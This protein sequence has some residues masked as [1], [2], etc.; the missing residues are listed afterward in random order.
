MLENRSDIVEEKITGPNGT[1]TYYS[2]KI[3]IRDNN[4][5]AIGMLGFSLDITEIKQKEEASRKVIDLLFD[6]IPFVFWKNIDG[7]YQGAN[8]NEAITMGF[9]SPNEMIGKTTFEVTSDKE[10]AKLVNDNDNKVMRENRS[11]IVEETIVGPNGPHT[12]YSQKTP[13]RDEMGKVT[14]MLG[15][16]MDITEHK[17]TVEKLRIEKEAA[18]LSSEIKTQFIQNM[19][20]DLRTPAS[21][22]AQIL[23]FMAED[24]TNPEKKTT[25]QQLA[26]ASQRLLDLLNGI[27]EFDKMST[28]QT[29]IASEKFD[30]YDI[31]NSIIQLETPTATNKKLKLHLDIA[32]TVPR[33]IIC[34]KNRVFRILL[35]LVGN[36]VKFTSKG[37]VKIAID[38]AKQ[39]DT[40]QII[41]GIVVEDTGIGI[42]YDRLHR[43]YER[44]ERCTPANKGLYPGSG[45]G[46]SITKQFIDELGGE[47]SAKS[48][49]GEGSTFTCLLP[50]GVSILDLPSYDNVFANIKSNAKTQPV[51]PT[52]IPNAVTTAVSTAT[53]TGI[54]DSFAGVKILVVEDDEIAQISAR[55]VF[56]SKLAT[57][58]ALAKTGKEALEMAGKNNYDII[59]MD[60]GL[61][62]IAGTEV[63]SKIRKTNKKIP[64]IALTAHD[65]QN[66]RE[67]CQNAGMNDYITKPLDIDKAQFMLQK[68]LGKEMG[69]S[70]VSAKPSPED[71]LKAFQELKREGHIPKAFQVETRRERSQVAE[72]TT[73]YVSNEASSQQSRSLKGEGYNNK[74]LD[75]ALCTGIADN[76]EDTARQLWQVFANLLPKYLEDIQTAYKKKDVKLLFALSHKLKG[77]AMYA[78]ASRLQIAT[79][80]LCEATRSGK[81]KIDAVKTLYQTTC[82]EIS[83]VMN[84]Y[85]ELGY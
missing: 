4:G 64:I 21:G 75:F 9:K 58:F 2:Q 18:E 85:K 80:D 31:V 81:T 69:E 72:H 3:P 70:K 56:E 14:G 24:E 77:A 74:I 41:L 57:D 13:I 32:K 40:R 36:A 61:P 34:D 71:I 28:G 48:T 76:N 15:F 23:K 6:N 84:K 7:V 35:N 16:S 68:W 27:L 29:A 51:E 26:N 59:F 82:K 45:L 25:L 43:I 49:E 19:E 78:G 44:F 8:L 54:Q 79:S 5:D 53:K 11:M 1:R 30:L 17:R 67:A 66:T 60:I 38:V 37:Y 39:V 62:D 20:H 73:R 42:P 52:K 22:V 63:T 12:Y 83:A 50:C 10:A 33:H 47:I 46:L 65:K 55:S